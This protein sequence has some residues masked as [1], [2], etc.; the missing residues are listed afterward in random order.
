MARAVSATRA[1][2]LEVTTNFGITDFPLGISFWFW[3]D[4]SA[5]TLTTVNLFDVSANDQ[6][7]GAEISAT[8]TVTAYQVNSSTAAAGPTAAVSDLSWNH[9]VLEFNSSTFRS[10]RLNGGSAVSDTTSLAFPT[11]LDTFSIFG[12]RDSSTDADDDSID[13]RIAEVA[14]WNANMAFFEIEALARGTSPLRIRRSALQGYWPLFGAGAAGESDQSGND[15]NLTEVGTVT[16]AGHAP[17]Q[18]P[19]AFSIGPFVGGTPGPLVD[20]RGRR[21]VGGVGHGV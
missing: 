4:A 5:S 19:F 11:G 15:R 20:I 9:V 17:I 7:F 12:R 6:R 21:I 3:L 13:G 10:V 18:P 1:D 16:V 14:I 8:G 2:G